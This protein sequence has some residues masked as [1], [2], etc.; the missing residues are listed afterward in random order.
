MAKEGFYA[1]V[2]DIGQ[3][4][5]Y[6][7]RQTYAKIVGDHLEDIAQARKADNYS[8][9]FKNLKDLY[10]IVKHKIKSKEKKTS[11]DDK[12]FMDLMKKAVETINL[13]PNEYLGA[14]KDPEPCALI[15]DAL[16]KM[17]MYLYEKMEE[18]KIFGSQGTLPGL[19]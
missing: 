12:N 17:E 13:Y 2:A 15:E 19:S 8:L 10:V 6:D 18:A 5:P 7:L 9:Y 14:S 4:L 3:E 16:N 11:K 1:G